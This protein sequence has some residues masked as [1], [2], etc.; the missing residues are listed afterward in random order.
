M[1]DYPN[2]VVERMHMD[3]QIVVK[4]DKYSDEQLLRHE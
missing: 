4:K 3:S 2:M 1:L